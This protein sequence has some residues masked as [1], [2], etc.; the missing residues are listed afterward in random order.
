MKILHTSDWHIGKK[1]ENIERLPEQALVLDEICRIA[2]AEAVDVVIVA[3]DVFDTYVPSAEAEELFYDRVV[4]LARDRAVVIIAGN[5][6]DATRLCAAAPLANKHNVY[7]SGNINFNRLTAESKEKRVF[8]SECGEGYACFKNQ[9][10]EAVYFGLLPYPTEARFNEKKSDL[11]H[12]ER[13]SAWLNKCMGETARN[14][15]SVLVSHLFAMGG[16]TSES[17]RE[18]TLGGSKIVPLE[19]FP[20]A[21]YVALGHLHK[22][23]VI[24]KSRNII[25]SGSILQYSFDEINIDK[26]VTV[27][28]ITES[29]VSDIREIKLT[30]GKRLARLS[31]CSVADAATVLS[32]YGDYWVELTLK[33]NGPLGRE[34]NNFLR[35]NYPNV[36]SLKLEIASEAGYRVKG[37]KDLDST[38]LFEQCYER[39]YGSA[40]DKALVELYLSLL[41]E[42]ENNEAD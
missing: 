28:D 39:K 18:I 38:M 4:K 5:H 36:I 20:E 17:E 22:R 23:Q 11:S 16:K 37:R 41:G 10:G 9:D 30:E 35:K 34:E 15:P 29:G 40:P 6:D 33:L 7:F 19:A 26:S 25:Y 1:T 12:G 27:F 14:L 31:A 3:G 24:S 2:E 32:G 13:I 8:L 21:M 42:V